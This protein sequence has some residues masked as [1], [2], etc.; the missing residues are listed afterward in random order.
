MKTVYFKNK[1]ANHS[2]NIQGKNVQFVNG[3]A[4][5]ED[6]KE[7]EKLAKKDE[8]SLRPFTVSKKK[9]KTAKKK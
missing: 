1:T 8:Y 3:K 6:D 9:K 5:I 7:A 2:V 4:E